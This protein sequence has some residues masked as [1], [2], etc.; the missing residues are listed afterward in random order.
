MKNFMPIAQFILKEAGAGILTP[1]HTGLRGECC[2]SK[3]YDFLLWQEKVI[4]ALPYF[5][6]M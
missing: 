5:G 6:S 1:C 2:N 4:G 3:S